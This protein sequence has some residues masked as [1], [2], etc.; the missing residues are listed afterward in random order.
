MCN[1]SKLCRQIANLRYGRL[2]VC[3]TE[4]DSSV[5]RGWLVSCKIVVR[6]ESGVNEFLRLGEFMATKRE[7]EEA[8]RERAARG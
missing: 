7:N 5:V 8:A 1:G 6:I 4:G 3:V 2:P